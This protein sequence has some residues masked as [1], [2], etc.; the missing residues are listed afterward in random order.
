[1]TDI[2][3]VEETI[4]NENVE[5]LSSDEVSEESVEESEPVNENFRWFIAKTLT[6]QENKVQKTLRERIINYKLS[7]F[8]GEIVV[9]EEKVTTH[10]GGKKRT[11][12]KKLFPG[13]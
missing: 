9:P 12:T 3:D 11:L 1:M 7:E 6:G 10:A 8:F 4:V 13:S 2:K 5:E